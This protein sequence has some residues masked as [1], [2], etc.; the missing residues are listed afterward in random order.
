MLPADSA[1]SATASEAPPYFNLPPAQ[2]KEPG[3][4]RARQLLDQMIQALGGRTWMD[5]QDMEQDGR[6]YVFFHGEPSGEGAL[7]RRLW[8]WPDKQRVEFTN[9]RELPLFSV[10]PP[11]PLKAATWVVIDNGNEGY[12]ITYRG[13]AKQEPEAVQDYV[14]RREHSLEWV[15]RKWLGEPGVAIFY[16]GPAIAERKPAEQVSIVNAQNDSVTIWI[17]SSTHLPLKKAFTWRDP[18]T[19]YRTEE[20][21]T[22][23][24]Y[25]PVQGIMTPFSITRYKNDDAVSQLFIT[26]ASINKGLA[27]SMFD[28]KAAVLP[29]KK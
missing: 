24:N 12:E 18:K 1:A 19:R 22:Y 2:A 11:V 5:M 21:E 15:L 16:E 26:E 29:Q 13:T 20:A 28:A 8:K 6:T 4:Q 10:L 3:V 23:E 25:R 9:R 7:F 27:D 17:D 14:R